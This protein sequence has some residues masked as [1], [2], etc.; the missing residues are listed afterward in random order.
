MKSQL[1]CKLYFFIILYLNIRYLFHWVENNV[2]NEINT[3]YLIIMFIPT[4]LIL[5]KNV[6]FRKSSF[7]FQKAALFSQLRFCCNSWIKNCVGPNG[8]RVCQVWWRLS[9]RRILRSCPCGKTSETWSRRLTCEGI[10]GASRQCEVQGDSQAQQT[11]MLGLRYNRVQ[12]F[13]GRQVTDN[14]TNISLHV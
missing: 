12:L 5:N 7:I 9:P 3:D 2:F 4:P 11:S 13:G 6:I 14:V 1:L 8:S 10:P